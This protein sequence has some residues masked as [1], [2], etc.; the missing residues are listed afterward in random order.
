VLTV[1][2]ALT[3][4]ACWTVM[5]AMLQLRRWRRVATARDVPV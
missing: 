3:M 5:P 4:L 1:G 2:I